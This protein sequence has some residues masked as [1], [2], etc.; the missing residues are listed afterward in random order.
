MVKKIR[1][2]LIGKNISYSFSRKYFDKKFSELKLNNYTYDNF[3]LEE[4]D[5][6]PAIIGENIGSIQG[7]NVTIPYKLEVFKYIDEID[8]DALAIGAVNTIKILD[9]GHLK[10][11][12]TDVYGFEHSLKPLLKKHVK[13]ALILGTGGASKAVTFVLNKLNIKHKYVSRNPK[14]IETFSYDELTENVMLNHHLIINCTPIGT[15][16]SSDVFP[17]IPYQYLT[18]KHFLYDLIYNPSETLFLSKGKEKGAIVK[19][20]LQMLELQADKAWEIWTT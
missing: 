7:L 13:S 5:E 9:N 15:H 19:N 14:N 16:P 8:D 2:G 12:N 20:G 17:K 18:N 11:F 6:F 3:D 10:G 4:I 1:F